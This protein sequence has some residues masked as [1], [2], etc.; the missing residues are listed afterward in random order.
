MLQIEAS[1]LEDGRDA[2]ACRFGGVYCS[3]VFLRVCP[4]QKHARANRSSDSIGNQ[5]SYKGG[6][7]KYKVH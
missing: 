2:T 3:E 4:F 1:A 6:Q 7:R 5:Y